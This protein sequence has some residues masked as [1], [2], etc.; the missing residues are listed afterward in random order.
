MDYVAELRQRATDADNKADQGDLSGAL[1]GYA[2]LLGDKTVADEAERLVFWAERTAWVLVRMGNYDEALSRCTRGLQH[3]ERHCPFRVSLRAAGALAN[4]F[5]GR[6]Q[7]SGKW[8]HKGAAALAYDPEDSDE[9]QR[10]EVLLRRASG[11]LAMAK[12]E[13]EEAVACFRQAV[14]TSPPEFAWDRSVALFNLGDALV[15]SGA[16]EEGLRYLSE[17]EHEKRRIGD[18]WGLAYVERSRARTLRELNQVEGALESA[19]RGLEVVQEVGDPKLEA[20]LQ[21]EFGLASLEA[22]DWEGAKLA[23]QEAMALA[24]QCHASSELVMGSV[25]LARVDIALGDASGAHGRASWALHMAR[26]LELPLEAAQAERVL[27]LCRPA[28]PTP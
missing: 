18:R 25:V 27:E 2:R 4:C 13:L 11:N 15:K 5:A 14:E 10:A 6:L 24:R 3:L 21:A 17:A 26:G 7:A 19:A 23:G 28:E 22:G 9:W 1:E 16:G 20:S 12:G 8:V